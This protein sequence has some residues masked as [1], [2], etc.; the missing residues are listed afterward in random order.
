[1]KDSLKEGYIIDFIS[2]EEVKAT[3]EGQGG[4]FTRNQIMW[5][6]FKRNFLIILL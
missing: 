6:Y 5:W 3:P 1:M 4:I 2:G